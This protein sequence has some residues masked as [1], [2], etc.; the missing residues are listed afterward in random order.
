MLN[1]SESHWRVLQLNVHAPR[2]SQKYL[3][4]PAAIF[5]NHPCNIVAFV[6]NLAPHTGARPSVRVCVGLNKYIIRQDKSSSTR[7]NL[8]VGSLRPRAAIGIWAESTRSLWVSCHR[9]LLF[10]PRLP[11]ATALYRRL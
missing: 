4:S 5:L 6:V 10:L 8:L 11:Q 7:G 9:P 3:I 1:W 2:R